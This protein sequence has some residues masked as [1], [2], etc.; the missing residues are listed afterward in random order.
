VARGAQTARKRLARLEASGPEQPI[1]E[2]R[3]W[4]QISDADRPGDAVAHLRAVSLRYGPQPVLA[5]VTLT[6]LRG[7]RVGVVGANG[8][9]KTSLLRLMARMI[10]PSSGEVWVGPGVRSGY[11]PQ[12]PAPAG[13]TRRV[14]DVPL[15]AGLV[16][17]EARAVLAALLFRGD[18]VFQPVSSLSGGE[19]TR[20]ALFELISHRVNLLL[21]DE[22]T[23]HLDLPSRERLEEA[24]EAFEGTLIIASHDRYLVDRLCATLWVIEGGT[25][26]VAAG[27]FS[28]PAP[29]N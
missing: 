16:P 8:S 1:A 7:A 22:P 17:S 23:N 18:R 29:S 6:L 14:I 25:V 13:P 4:L 15:D 5:N 9:G 20:L 3:L 24:L 12:E 2:Q 10:E 28:G 26:R 27:N 21:L 19:R 11:L